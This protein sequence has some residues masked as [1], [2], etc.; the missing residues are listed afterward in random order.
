MGFKAALVDF[1][2]TLA[3]SMPCWMDLPWQAF[4]RAGLTPP[5]DFGE[6]LRSVPMWEVAERLS[7]DYPSLSPERP[8]PEYWLALMEENYLTRVE[9]KPGALELLAL[10]REAGVQ[11]YV[12]SATRQ[13]MLGTALRHFDLEKH[14]DGVYTEDELGT[15]RSPA[16]YEYF[17]GKLGCDLSELLLIEDAARNLEA[18][19]A[20]GL[21]TVGVYDAAMEE[22]LP[23]LRQNAEVYL[24]DFS[25]LT[26]LRRR[27]G[28]G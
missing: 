2:G 20:L 4:R 11:I 24:P 19:R 27:L 22:D 14:L 7:A 10:L 25:D 17:A 26:P 6:L 28:L 12:L 21:G 16:P 8:L 5:E 18:A 23:L 15:K 13:P 9:L 3:D 1:D